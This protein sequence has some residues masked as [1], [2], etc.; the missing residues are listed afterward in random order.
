[1]NGNPILLQKKYARVIACFAH[2]TGLSLDYALKFFY[3]SEVYQLVRDGV[4]DMHCMSD[5]YL[6]DELKIEYQAK[7]KE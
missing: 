7:Y 6:A 3:A 5:A 2:K 1:M 4:S